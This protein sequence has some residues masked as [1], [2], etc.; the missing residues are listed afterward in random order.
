MQIGIAQTTST[1]LNIFY[2]LIRTIALTKLKNKLH[3]K[4]APQIY[5]VESNPVIT[6]NKINNEPM[7]VTITMKLYTSIIPHSLY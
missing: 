7:Y 2:F 6:I 1:F 5:A 3:I 4:F